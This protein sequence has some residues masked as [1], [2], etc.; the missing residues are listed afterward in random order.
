MMGRTVV[1]IGDPLEE[2]LELF[3]T[4][5]TE[6]EDCVEPPEDYGSVE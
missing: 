3:S 5:W 2:M 1:L 4:N 6:W